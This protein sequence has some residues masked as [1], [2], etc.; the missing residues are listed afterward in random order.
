MD[1][2]T[3]LGYEL[4]HASTESPVSGVEYWGRGVVGA[5]GSAVVD[6]PE[7]FGALIKPGTDHIAVTGNGG[8]VA[9]TD[10]LDNQFIVSGAAGTA[11]TWL[12]KAERIGADFPP[13]KLIP[14]PEEPLGPELPK[15]PFVNN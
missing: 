2:P 9:W 4:L 10:I 11:F 12:V 3:K 15:I 13:E 6:L 1:H 7:Y 5:E 8:Q 14:L